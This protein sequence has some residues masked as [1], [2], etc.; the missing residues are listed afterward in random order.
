MAGSGMRRGIHDGPARAEAPVASGASV[1]VHPRVRARLEQTV[2]ERQ[3]M[4]GAV[5]R[6]AA[7]R[8]CDAISQLCSGPPEPHP[9]RLTVIAE[10][11]HS[12]SLCLGGSGK[13]GPADLARGRAEWG[14]AKKRLETALARDRGASC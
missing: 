2:R 10:L 5:K 7:V 1:E 12:L 3:A 4:L 6:N 14:A 8:I 11:M 13:Q 9:A